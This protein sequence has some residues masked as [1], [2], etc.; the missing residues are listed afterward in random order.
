MPGLVP[1]IHPSTDAGASRKLDPGDKHRDDTP[2]LDF[3]E[4]DP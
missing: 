2:V 1:G 3:R 4:A